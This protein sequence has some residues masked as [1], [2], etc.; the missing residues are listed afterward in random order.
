M[1]GKPIQAL[2]SAGS[3]NPLILIDEIDKLARGGYQGDPA[4][5]LLEL[6]DP[7]QNETFVD[8][9]IDLPIDFSRVLFVCRA[10]DESM[11]PGPLRDR[12]EIIRLAGYDIP[13]KVY[14]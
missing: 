13:E 7:I 6:L 12:M 8:H 14:S 4:S 1:P 5:A 2:K 10:N 3:S 11:I 9:F